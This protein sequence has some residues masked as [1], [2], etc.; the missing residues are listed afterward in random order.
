MAEETEKA[1]NGTAEKQNWGRL[2]VNHRGTEARRTVDKRDG[3][4][5]TAKSPKYAKKDGV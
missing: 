2:A 3:D 1:R 5:L 4:F